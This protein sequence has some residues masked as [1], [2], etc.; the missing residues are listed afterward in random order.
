[1]NT[2]DFEFLRLL[3]KQKSG[4]IITPDKAYLLESRLI[5]ISRKWKHADIGALVIAMRGLADP[6]LIREVVESMNSH[7]TWFFR[8]LKLFRH[9]ENHMLPYLMKARAG[10]KK[11]RIWC[12]ASSSGQEAYSLAMMLREKG[13]LAQGWKVEII[14]TD[15]DTEVLAR[16]QKAE[17]SQFEVQRG[18]PVT[19]LIKYFNQMG[20]R[21]QLKD[22]IRKMVTLQPMNLLDPYTA[23]GQFDVVL[24]RN[25]L[26][27]FDAQTRKDVL[28][29]IARQ[30]AK[31]GFLLLGANETALGITESV[32][33][34]PQDA[35]ICALPGSVHLQAA[36]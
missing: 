36:A 6:K 11:I 19:H 32:L 3:L 2:S 24:C 33:P 35:S 10:Q 22:D 20:P 25:V 15:I 26:G 18:L 1:M 17:Y 7:E 27:C 29:R 12:A 31:D 8:D 30:T 9:F 16:A 5:P 34:V 23:L 21:W 28:D 13:I 4:L 14:A